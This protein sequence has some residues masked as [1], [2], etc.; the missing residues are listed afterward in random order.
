V[1]QHWEFEAIAGP[2][3]FTEGP[4]WDGNG[5]LFSD[6]ANSRIMRYDTSTNECAV[7]RKHTNRANGLKM[8]DAGELFACEMSGRRVIRYEPDKSDVTVAAEYEG[9]RLNSPNDLAFDSQGRLWFSDPFYGEGTVSDDHELELTH[10]SV[11]RADPVDKDDWTLTRM[12]YDTANPNGLLVSPDEE[13][14]YVAEYEPIDPLV[15]ML[16]RDVS[17]LPTVTLRVGKWLPKTRF[18][19][20]FGKSLELRRYPIEGNDLGTPDVLHDFSPYRPID[21]MCLDAD[22][23]IVAAA[24]SKW[25]GP[26]A[27][28]YVFSP[29]GDVLETHPTPDSG[30]TNCAFGGPDLRTLYLTG[31]EG[32]L[33]RAQTDRK[34]LLSAPKS[35]WVSDRSS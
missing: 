19:S 1:G 20:D 5:V 35:T 25:D 34:G 27:N 23:N 22:G 32:Y 3:G 9:K 28:V 13:W 33:Y 10:R 14:L 21:G 16:F 11:Y 18:S 17:S 12:T 26:G 15:F 6:I 31:S 24:G 8:N 4:V 29:Q 30:P 2:F 7:Y